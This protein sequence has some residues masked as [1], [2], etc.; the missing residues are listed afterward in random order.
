MS[1]AAEF[2]CWHAASRCLAWPAPQVK[3]FL[4][5]LV[6]VMSGFVT[7]VVTLFQEDAAAGRGHKVGGRGVE[8]PQHAE[9][10]D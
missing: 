1:Q 9:R 8:R 7:A 2:A 6:L 3:W 4:L 5:F 10:A